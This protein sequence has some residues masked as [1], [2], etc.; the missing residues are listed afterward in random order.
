MT[1]DAPGARPLVDV[2]VPTNRVSP[3]LETALASV[4]AQTYRRW[5]L[6]VVDDGSGRGDELERIVGSV[7]GARLIHRENGG[8]AAAR[9]TA[10]AAGSGDVVAFLD[11]DDRWPA[12]RLERLVAALGA[13]PEAIGAF[14]DGI[15]V[16]GDGVAFDAWHT[17]R[18]TSDAYLRGETPIPRI[19]TLVVRRHAFALA[20]TFDEDFGLSQDTEFTLRLLRHG[21]LVGCGAPVVEYRRHD[22]NATA[23]D[24]RRLHAAGSRAVRTNLE[25]AASRGEDAHV[26]ALRRNARLLDR[27]Y[28]SW[29]AGRVIGLLRAGRRRQAMLDVRDSL[30]LS[31]RGVVA[32]WSSTIASRLRNRAGRV[33]RDH[34][35]G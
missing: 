33:R 31:P 32:G 16:D 23:A 19:T 28:A 6:I 15:D 1:T 3:Y 24:W 11:D 10:I 22:R 30:R 4:A 26:D 2:V 13:D 27:A 17:P 29:S 12:D 7:D 5:S 8:A 21:R 18:A 25:D 34:A 14:G 35:A 20:G 9:N